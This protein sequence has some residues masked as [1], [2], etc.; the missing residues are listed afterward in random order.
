MPRTIVGRGDEA[1]LY[2]LHHDRLVR[3]VA[4]VVNA[5]A[6][7]VEDACQTAWLILLRRQPDR[8]PTL[9]GWL[10]TVA[11]H[12]AYRLSGEDCRHAR[13]EE[14]AEG[15]EWEAVAG[16]GP[17]LEDAV[18]ARRAL[19]VLAPCRRFSARIWRGRGR[20]RVCRDRSAGRPPPLA[21]Q[22]QQAPGQGAGRI[23]RLEATAV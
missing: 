23:R 16:E 18:E 9:F 14:L 22:C 15:G 10:R 8:G 5:P 4:R 17:S 1:E 3:A 12:E 20:V 6:A 13:L 11:V 19:A 7:L 21:Q 2:L